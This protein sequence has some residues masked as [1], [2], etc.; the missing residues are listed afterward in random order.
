[1][2]FA[3]A[4][5]PYL[6]SGKRHYAKHHP[7]ARDCDDPAWHEALIARLVAEYPD[8]WAL[9]AASPSLRVLLP[10]CPADVRVLSWVKPFAVFKPNVGVAYAWEPVIVRGGRRRERS[11]PTI[12]DWF[13]HEVTMKKG[14]IGAK[15]PA[16]VHWLMDVLNVRRGDEIHDLFPGTGV[17]GRCA[18]VRTQGIH[19]LADL[20]LGWNTSPG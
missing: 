11:Q 10:M 8:G 17:V 12:R 14:L 19:S 2:K 9:S 3:Y 18:I 1:M 20:P 16:F 13:S 6:G 15:P 5:P 4:D 7:D